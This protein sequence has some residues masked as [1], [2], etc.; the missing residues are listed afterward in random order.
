MSTNSMNHLWITSRQK[1]LSTIVHRP[2][3][4]PFVGVLILCHGFTAD[5]V[6][7]GQL[8]RTIAE[9]VSALGCVAIRFDFAGSGD[10]EGE[11]VSDTSISGWKEDLRNIINWVNSQEQYKDLPI[12]LLGHS[13]GGTIILLYENEHENKKKPIAARIAL[14]PVIYPLEN[15]RDIILGRLAWDQANK[16]ETIQNVNGKHLSLNPQF[17]QDIIQHNFSTIETSKKYTCP[18]YIFHGKGD[19]AVPFEGSRDF[20]SQ[21]PHQKDLVLIDNMDHHFIQYLDELKSQIIK[22]LNLNATIHLTENND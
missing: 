22:W 1:R 11:F 3:G 8:L 5:K 12:Y 18:V 2:L 9:T 15:F 20:Y 7:P 4:T 16:G 21:Y 6:G 14:A 17:V 13:L 19:I 10:S